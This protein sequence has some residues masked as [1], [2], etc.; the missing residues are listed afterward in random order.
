MLVRNVGLKGKNKLADKWEKEV[1]LVVDQPNKDVPVFVVKREHGR[2]TR[3]LLH[4][5]LL[6]P[7]M[8]LPVSKPNSLETSLL[9]D[10]NQPLPADTMSVIDSTRQVKLAGTISDNEDSSG[11]TNDAVNVRQCLLISMFC[12]KGELLLILWQTNFIPNLQTL[13]SQ[14]FCLREVGSHLHGKRPVIGPGK[15]SFLLQFFLPV[16]F[17]KPLCQ[18]VIN[19]SSFNIV[20]SCCI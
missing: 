10:G 18:P 17:L 6:L 20:Q 3:K 11:A 16:L 13:R 7:F 4:R 14:G 1:Y 8:A 15:Q 19:T 9:I 5:N 2:S 12:H